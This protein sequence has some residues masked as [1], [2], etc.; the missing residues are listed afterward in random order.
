MI[1]W[2]CVYA[3]Y[4]LQFHNWLNKNKYKNIKKQKHNEKNIDFDFKGINEN[5][6][7]II[8]NIISSDQQTTLIKHLKLGGKFEFHMENNEKT[9]FH[10]TKPISL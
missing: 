5:D 6:V 8:G 1:F 4:E 10:Q 2:L 3:A 9:Y 7:V